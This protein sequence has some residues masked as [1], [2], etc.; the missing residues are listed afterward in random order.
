[1][2]LI[3]N[4]VLVKVVLMEVVAEA[5]KMEPQGID[6]KMEGLEHQLVMVLV[7]AAFIQTVVN[8]AKAKTL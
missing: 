6:L 5:H 3:V 7:E 4:T 2:V 1:M 8:V